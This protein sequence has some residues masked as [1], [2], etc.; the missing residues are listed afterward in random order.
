MLYSRADNKVPNPCGPCLFFESGAVD[1]A[2]RG[3]VLTMCMFRWVYL[4][5][6]GCQSKG[7]TDNREEGARLEQRPAQQLDLV[8]LAWRAT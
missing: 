4:V 6:V 5:G 3:V 2:L 8:R 1:F 7:K